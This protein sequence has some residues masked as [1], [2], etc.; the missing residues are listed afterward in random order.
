MKLHTLRLAVVASSLLLTTA[1]EKD[2]LDQINLISPPRNR[3]GKP[4]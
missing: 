3:S 4:S 1:C 2:Y